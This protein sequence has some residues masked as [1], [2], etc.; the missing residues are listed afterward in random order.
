[1]SASM[2][3]SDDCVGAGAACLWTGSELLVYVPV[4]E[5][6]SVWTAVVDAVCYGCS[7]RASA[8]EV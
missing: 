1:M 8:D 6:D 3:C 5:D 7:Y 4:C 2:L